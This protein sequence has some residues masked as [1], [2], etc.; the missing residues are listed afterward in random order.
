MHNVSYY[1]LGPVWAEENLAEE[2]GLEAVSE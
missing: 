2:K 1:R